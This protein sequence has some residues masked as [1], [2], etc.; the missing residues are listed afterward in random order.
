MARFIVYAK[1]TSYCYVEVEAASKQDAELVAE[2]MDGGDFNPSDLPSD[3][4]WEIVPEMT[5]EL[6]EGE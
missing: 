2:E 1:M 3:G 6:K 4:S 5:R